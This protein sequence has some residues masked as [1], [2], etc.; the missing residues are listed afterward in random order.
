MIQFNSFYAKRSLESPA[1]AAEFAQKVISGKVPGFAR[2]THCR[3]RWRYPSPERK[4]LMM[5]RLLVGFASNRDILWQEPL[6]NV[7]T[8]SWGE[9]PG[10]LPT[11]W[12]HKDSF[13]IGFV[14]EGKDDPFDPRPFCVIDLKLSDG[15]VLKKGDNSDR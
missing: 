2:I 4:R 6:R 9:A 12:A 13:T 1:E 7:R 5:A 14:W 3:K 8:N 10:L 15:T 11:V